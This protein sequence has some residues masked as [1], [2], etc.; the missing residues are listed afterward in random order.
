[1]AHYA[2]REKCSLSDF[3]TTK[4]LSAQNYMFGGFY[5]ALW[6]SGVTVCLAARFNLGTGCY[7]KV[8]QT[9][10]QHEVGILSTFT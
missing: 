5:G 1:M 9:V 2:S 7:Y 10:M 6:Q 3:L 8:F 4:R